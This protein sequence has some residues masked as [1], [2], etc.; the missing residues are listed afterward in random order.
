[1]NTETTQFKIKDN[2]LIEEAFELLKSVELTDENRK[3]ISQKFIKLMD[4]EESQ[5]IDS[6][7][8]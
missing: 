7:A 4:D 3:L 1:M 6:D 8:N 2:Q 5:P